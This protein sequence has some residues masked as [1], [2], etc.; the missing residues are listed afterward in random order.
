[1]VPLAVFVAVSVAVASTV[2]MVVVRREFLVDV[3]VAA[4]P[5]AVLSRSE[6]P[7]MS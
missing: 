6:L 2:S 1:M 7:G 5:S 3:A 4:S